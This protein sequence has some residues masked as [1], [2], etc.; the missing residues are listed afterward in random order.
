MVQEF[1]SV[2]VVQ[3]LVAGEADGVGRSS[4]DSRGV[5]LKARSSSTYGRSRADG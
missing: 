2:H 4:D 1:Q 3:E 5:N